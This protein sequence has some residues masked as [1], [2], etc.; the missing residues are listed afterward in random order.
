MRSSNDL[1]KKTMRK[2]SKTGIKK[3]NEKKV[4]V[5]DLNERKKMFVDLKKMIF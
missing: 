2:R 5:D 4:L 1:W 3:K